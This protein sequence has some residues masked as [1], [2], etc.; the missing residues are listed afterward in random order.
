VKICEA[1]PE[2]GCEIK[3]IVFALKQFDLEIVEEKMYSEI[4]NIEKHLAN[5]CL[6]LVN[7]FHSYFGCHH[8]SVIVEQDE[9][10]FYFED[11]S[12]GLFRLGKDEFAKFWHN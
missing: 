4:G 5:N 1:T 8:Y 9:K 3:D 12:F 7:Y 6:V 2:N 10:S 11:S